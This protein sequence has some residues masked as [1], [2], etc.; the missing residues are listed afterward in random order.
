MNPETVNLPKDA[1]ICPTCATPFV[2]FAGITPGHSQTVRKGQYFVC[3]HCS[4]LSTVGDG[5][6]ENVS[7]EKFKALPRHVQEAIN[8]VVRTIRDTSVK[9]T[10]LN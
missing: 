1:L 4:N 6:L 5:N 3:A 10:D 2:Q 9:Q 8:A 7:E